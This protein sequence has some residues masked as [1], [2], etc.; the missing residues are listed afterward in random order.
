[1]DPIRTTKRIV[2]LLTVAVLWMGLKKGH[3]HYLIPTT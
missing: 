1:M 2:V 3:P